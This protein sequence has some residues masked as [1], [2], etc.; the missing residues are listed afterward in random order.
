VIIS[1]TIRVIED[2][3][4]PVLSFLNYKLRMLGEKKLEVTAKLN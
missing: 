4:A 1:L 3:P 2:P